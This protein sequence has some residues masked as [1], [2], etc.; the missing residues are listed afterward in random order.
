MTLLL[1][2]YIRDI[3]KSLDYDDSL[4][5]VKYIDESMDNPHFSEALYTYFKDKHNSFLDNELLVR[6]D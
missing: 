3:V 1:M 5:L 4:Q 2:I 6:L